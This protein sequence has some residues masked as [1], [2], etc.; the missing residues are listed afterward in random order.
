MYEQLIRLSDELRSAFDNNRPVVALE[1]SFLAH[2]L[3]FPVNIETAI[4]AERRIRDAGAIP[5]MIAVLNG[6]IAIGLSKHEIESLGSGEPV[7]KVGRADLPLALAAAENAAT[8]VSS[9]MICASYAGIDVFATGGIGGVH[10][11]FEQTFD[12]SQDLNELATTS[13][14]VVASGAKSVLDIP[15]TLEHMETLG[16]TIA[17]RDQDAFPAFW[18]R[19]SGLPSPN[20]LDE[21]AQIASTLVFR[22]QLNIAG[23]VFAANPIPVED[24]VPPSRIAP[25]IDAALCEADERGITGKEATPFLLES[26]ARQSEGAT[27]QANKAL[28]LNNAEFAAEIADC[29]CRQKTLHE[30]SAV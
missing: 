24:E 30:H 2:G 8:T 14:I 26:I 27:V 21:P 22:R 15:K 4:G 11:N 13:M 3:P 10:R 7:A 19:D 18:S 16:I 20:R 28:I 9:T 6:K 29:L 1:S 5:A 12:I 23:A 17:V 25:W